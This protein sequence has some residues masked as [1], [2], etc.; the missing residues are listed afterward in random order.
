[1]VL[2]QTDN[3][4][5]SPYKVMRLLQNHAHF[6][7]PRPPSPSGNSQISCAQLIHVC[8]PMKIFVFVANI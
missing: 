6:I 2:Q 5:W 7:N 8:R 3:F 1:M 4:L